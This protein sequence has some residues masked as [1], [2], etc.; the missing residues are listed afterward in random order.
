VRVV[1]RAF[2]E[3]SEVWPEED[4]DLYTVLSNTGPAKVSK[5]T[6]DTREQNWQQAH[7][8]V[9]VW[10]Q[11]T[12]RHL[13]HLEAR[14]SAHGEDVERRRED[15]REDERRAVGYGAEHKRDDCDRDREERRCD[16]SELRGRTEGCGGEERVGREREAEDEVDKE[17]QTA[18]RRREDAEVPEDGDQDP[19]GEVGKRQ[20]EVPGTARASVGGGCV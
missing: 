14:D 7:A 8:R 6:H 4:V 12:R 17:D 18:G 5:H 13:V 15:E 11:H 3:H 9:R 10:L 20:R 2:E 19:S 16:G 1:E